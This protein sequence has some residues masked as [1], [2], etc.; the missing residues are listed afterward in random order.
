MAS[1]QVKDLHN[2]M[3][4]TISEMLVYKSDCWDRL[5]GKLNNSPLTPKDKG[6]INSIQDL[7]EGLMDKEYIGYGD[8]EKL[9]KKMSGIHNLAATEVMK[10]EKRIQRQIEM[11][12][13]ESRKIGKR[14]RSENEEETGRRQEDHR[15]RKRVRRESLGSNRTVTK[16]EK[17]KLH[18]DMVRELNDELGSG[19]VKNWASFKNNMKY[20]LDFGEA[21]LG[22]ITDMYSACKEMMAKGK[23]EIGKY[24]K[25][26]E[27]VED[28]DKKLVDIINKYLEKMGIESTP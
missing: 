4:D 3:V 24:D 18:G 26:I 12:E 19:M 23:I 17:R 25:L 15:A 8:Y 13:E 27:V 16:D 7:F 20:K 22:D 21:V 5:L 28:V 6:L 14:R 2:K 11:D 9:R 10:Y 1:E